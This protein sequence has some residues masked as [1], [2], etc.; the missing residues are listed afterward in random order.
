M[1]PSSVRTRWIL[2]LK[3]PAK[4]VN[5]GPVLHAKFYRPRAVLEVSCPGILKSL[6][7]KLF[8][9]ERSSY[10]YSKE[11]TRVIPP[12]TAFSILGSTQ[13]LNAAKLIAKIDQGHGLVDGIL[14]A[15]PLAYRP[16]LTEM[17]AAKGQISTE[18]VE[19]FQQLFENIQNCAQME[20]SFDDD[21][22]LLFR[23][24][25]SW[26]V[27]LG[28][29]RSNWG[30]KSTAKIENDRAYSQDLNRATCV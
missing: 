7:C 23:E 30:G 21:A 13:L 4:D 22:C 8:S 19:D 29:Q 17:E 20:F 3:V 9:G 1:K 24:T 14:F 15:T 10:H 26:P 2:T 18:V 5:I 6:L 27:G 11:D 16:T 25:A 12:N 28:R